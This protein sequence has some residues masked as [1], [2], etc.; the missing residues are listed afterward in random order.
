MKKVYQKKNQIKRRT[1]KEK[2]NYQRKTRNLK[3]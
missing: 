2:K 1:I 3:K